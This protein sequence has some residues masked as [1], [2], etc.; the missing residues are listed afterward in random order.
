MHFRYVEV[1]TTAA[2]RRRI[3]PTAS[4]RVSAARQTGP[5]MMIARGASPGQATI[6]ARATAIILAGL[7]SEGGFLVPAQPER[8]LLWL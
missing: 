8:I 2:L 6:M 5:D 7:A 4:V 1:D 3:L